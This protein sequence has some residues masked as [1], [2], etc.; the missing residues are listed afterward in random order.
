MNRL[1]IENFMFSARADD[2]PQEFRRALDLMD[3]HKVPGHIEVL[4]MTMTTHADLGADEVV[5]L[6]VQDAQFCLEHLLK[7][8]GIT[9]VDGLTLAKVSD[10]VE[11]VDLLDE[12][13]DAQALK[14]IL[15]TPWPSEMDSFLEC[16][17]LATARPV[18]DFATLIE[19]VHAQ[20]P[21]M[22]LDN[23][24]ARAQA[25]AESVVTEQE[26]LK[27]WGA[28]LT[29]VEGAESSFANEFV[30]SPEMVGL[31]FDTYWVIWG[32]TRGKNY[33]LTQE[34]DVRDICLDLI[35]LACLSS[36][37][38]GTPLQALQGKIAQITPDVQLGV[39]ISTVAQGLCR[40][41]QPK[42]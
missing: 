24:K 31:P 36:D 35:G 42:R 37:C 29:H 34:D 19:S 4:A 38:Q 14:D 33:D 41:L 27:A 30:E 5:I 2:T 28:F 32:G 13:E 40:Q 39:K 16:L 21:K 20:V 11:S 6:L 23:L 12:Y 7:V 8:Q 26:Q 25:M 1:E 17:S 18:E 3:K 15:E 9:P 22:L 10:L